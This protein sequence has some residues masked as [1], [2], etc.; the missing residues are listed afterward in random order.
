MIAGLGSAE[1][2]TTGVASLHITL[3]DIKSIK[4]TDFQKN[5]IAND[6]KTDSVGLNIMDPSA[7]QL[8]VT[9]LHFMDQPAIKPSSADERS[10][11]AKIS[12]GTANRNR[13]AA[14]IQ[15][16]TVYEILPR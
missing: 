4:V 14:K 7:V 10:P 6:P 3:S 16:I 1:A 5:N 9:R 12:M 15:E 13:S 2:Q 11:V 8:K